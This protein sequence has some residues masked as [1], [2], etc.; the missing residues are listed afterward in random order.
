[1]KLSKT[2]RGLVTTTLAASMVLSMAGCAGKTDGGD[3][4]APAATEKTEEAKE[5]TAETKTSE[6]VTVDIFQFKVEIAEELQK[7]IDLYTSKNP[8]VTINLTTVGGGDDYGAA[9]KAKFQSGQEPTIYNVG[10]PQD[11]KDWME[12]LEDLGDQPWVGTAGG[13]LGAV[14]VDGKPY[15]MPLAVEGYGVVYNKAIFEAA[16]VDPSTV[17]DIASMDAAFAAIDA[18]IKSG[19]LK[20][21]FPLLEAVAELPAKETWVTG[22]HSSNIFINKE[23]P[24]GVDAFNAKEIKFEN[25]ADFKAYLDLMVKYS[26]NAASPQ[27]LNAVDY[28]TQV[29]QGLAIERVAAI[30]QGNWVFGDVNNVDPA[31]AENLAFLPVGGDSIPLGVPMY[32][33]VNKGKADAEKQAAKDFLNWLYTSDEGKDIVVN[34]FFFIPP[35]TGF[36]NYPAKDA[37]GRDIMRYQAEGKTTSWVFMGY[38]T[39]WGMDILGVNIQKYL[40]G[41]MTWDKVISESQ[42][43]WAEARK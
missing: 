17:K 11:V 27:K 18:K 31:V 30:Q 12:K 9:L 19:E 5:E 25:N 21:K 13:T 2:I 37:L 28:A 42:A 33:A 43:K 10:G 22:L 41:E 8:N 26:P 6:P 36:D 40:A 1:M 24:T 16:G 14:T 39:A 34:K 4:T 15:G 20:E 3:T 32:W 35:F 7:A 23:F 38:P 29:G